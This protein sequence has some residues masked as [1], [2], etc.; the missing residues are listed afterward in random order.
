MLIRL[1]ILVPNKGIDIC[2]LARRLR[3]LA[4]PCQINVLLLGLSGRTG[5]KGVSTRL[6]LVALWAMTRDDHVQ[7]DYRV[8]QDDNWVRA[9]HHVLQPGDAVICMAEQMIDMGACGCRPLSQVIE[10][11]LD[12]PVYVLPGMY[13]R[14]RASRPRTDAQSARMVRLLSKVAILVLVIAVFWAQVQ[15]DLVTTGI[16]RTGLLCASSLAE[17]GL[18]GVWSALIS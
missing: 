11:L 1:I 4:T 9:I 16:L 17:V 6:R 15:I 5:H 12:V 8:E 14:E 13:A 3:A 18:I 10:D 7:V 2:A